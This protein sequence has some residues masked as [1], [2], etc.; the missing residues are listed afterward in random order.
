VLLLAILV[1]IALDFSLPAMPGAFVFEVDECIQTVQMQRS[2]PANDV[3]AAPALPARPFVLPLPVE[4]T[5]GPALTRDVRTVARPL[6]RHRSRATLEP[7]PP[8]EDPH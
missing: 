3:L 4:R 6:V 1:Y 7:T 5:D 8:T 2:R